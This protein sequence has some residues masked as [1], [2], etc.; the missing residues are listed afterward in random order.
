MKTAHMVKI[1]A[2]AIFVSGLMVVLSMPLWANFSENKTEEYAGGVP[3]DVRDLV[4]K[5][6]VK[7]LQEKYYGKDDDERMM[8][9]CPSGVHSMFTATEINKEGFY[10]GKV[11]NWIGCSRKELCVFRANAT[12]VEV[13][14]NGQY[15][16]VD[17]WMNKPMAKQGKE[18]I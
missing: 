10:T 2:L 1:A 3:Q 8:S 14:E 5:K 15:L 9:R 12:T 6:L 7:P 16:S 17:A 18:E 13:E 11:N 4:E